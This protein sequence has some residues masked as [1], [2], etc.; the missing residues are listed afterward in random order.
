M[1]V[2]LQLALDTSQLLL[3][4]HQTLID[5][6]RGIDRDL[7]LVLDSLLVIHRDQRI[8]HILR[9]GGGVI[10]QRQI[11]DG[12]VILRLADAQVASEQA[13]HRV[14]ALPAHLYR[15]VKPLLR[16]VQSWGNDQLSDRRLDGVAHIG[17]QRDSCRVIREI[18]QPDLL[19]AQDPDSQAEGEMVLLLGERYLD[20]GLRVKL[21]LA[22]LIHDDVADIGM[23]TVHHV[24]HQLVRLKLQDLIRYIRIRIGIE[25][26]QPTTDIVGVG[27][28]DHHS[29][30]SR[31]DKW[32]LGILIPSI[33]AKQT[34]R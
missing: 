25:T 26:I 1:L 30:R 15:C 29:S 24:A 8:Q 32:C 4:N 11:E 12:S 14:R 22:Q 5:E 16:E 18:R 19:L 17:G 33:S 20:R 21:L 13:G 27:I 23:K 7:V 9:T 31:I 2:R 10:P 28:F 6:I 34:D 3:D